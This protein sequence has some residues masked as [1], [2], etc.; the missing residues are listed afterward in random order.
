MVSMRK[1]KTHILRIMDELDEVLTDVFYANDG[2]DGK[3]KNYALFLLHQRM[4]RNGE[5]IRKA[6]AGL[7]NMKEPE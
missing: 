1:Y 4:C 7:H 5:Q 2:E 3:P 6:A